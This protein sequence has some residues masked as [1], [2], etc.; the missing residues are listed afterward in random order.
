MS[1][2]ET[3]KDG[4]PRL[5][6]EVFRDPRTKWDR[7]E[8]CKEIHKLLSVVRGLRNEEFSLSGSRM[9]SKNVLY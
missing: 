5:R 7:V 2:D 9:L 4:R 8:S 3:G 6:L 1:L